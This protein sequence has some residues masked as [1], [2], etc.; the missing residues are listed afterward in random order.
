MSGLN[1]IPRTGA[2]EVPDP[3]AINGVDFIKQIVD[4]ISEIIEPI[5]K[6]VYKA[7]AGDSSFVSILSPRLCPCDN[8]VHGNAG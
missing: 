5:D 6:E 2:I 1:W 7:S 3:P 8:P 4:N